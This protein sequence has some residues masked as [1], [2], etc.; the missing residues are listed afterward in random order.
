MLIESVVTSVPYFPVANSKPSP[1]ERLI[2]LQDALPGV[3]KKTGMARKLKIIK[4][5]VRFADGVI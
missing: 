1:I 3:I 2:S 4:L 5:A